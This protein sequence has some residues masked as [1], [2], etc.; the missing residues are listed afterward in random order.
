LENLDDLDSSIDS[1]SSSNQSEVSGDEG[2]TEDEDDTGGHM[3]LQA[4]SNEESKTP[5]R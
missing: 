1:S 3:M 4:I 2:H 5:N